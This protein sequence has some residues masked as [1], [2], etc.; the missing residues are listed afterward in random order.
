MSSRKDNA[1]YVPPKQ[2]VKPP[3]SGER[4]YVPPKQPVKPPEKPT[5]GKK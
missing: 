2:P 3:N 5:T 4:G 1:G